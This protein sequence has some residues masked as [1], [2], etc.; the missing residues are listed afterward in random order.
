M[1]KRKNG[2]RLLGV[3]DRRRNPAIAK[4]EAI[5]SKDCFILCNY[6]LEREPGALSAAADARNAKKKFSE[7][8]TVDL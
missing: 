1:A 8:K 3:R 4:N 7:L 6:R 2:Q 5:S